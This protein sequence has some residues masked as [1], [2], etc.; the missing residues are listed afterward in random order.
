MSICPS[1]DTCPLLAVPLNGRKLGRSARVGHDVHF[2]CNA[3]FQLVGSE[4]RTCRRDRTW[5]GTQPFC[6]SEVPWARGRGAAQGAIS[7]PLQ[8]LGGRKRQKLANPAPALV[9]FMG[10]FSPG[11]DECS[12]NPCA[13]G[14]TCVDGNQRYTCLCPRGWSGVSCQSPVYACRC[15]QTHPQLS[16]GSDLGS[17]ALCIP[18]AEGDG[19]LAGPR[20]D[21][22]IRP[23]W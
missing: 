13:N 20:C 11:I 23:R 9:V 10:S 6:R 3:G 14:G 7:R 19:M 18:G 15:S 21:H 1:A 16:R 5:S 2:I 4:S 17:G 12:S 8:R 22:L